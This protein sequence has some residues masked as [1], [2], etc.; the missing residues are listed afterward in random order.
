MNNMITCKI[1]AW[2]KVVPVE[3]DVA[4]NVTDMAVPSPFPHTHTHSHPLSF[5]SFPFTHCFS[6]IQIWVGSP[7]ESPWIQHFDQPDPHSS[8]LHSYYYT[9]YLVSYSLPLRPST[10]TITNR[11][12]MSAMLTFSPAAAKASSLLSPAPLLR[13]KPPPS[14]T[15][16]LTSGNL[17][18]SLSLSINARDLRRT[19]QC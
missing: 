5:P 19:D 3:S 11:S 1:R 12:V 8:Y 4:T 18:L 9:S 15:A 16:V 2:S 7:S 13:R 6:A 14:T 17:S 10:S